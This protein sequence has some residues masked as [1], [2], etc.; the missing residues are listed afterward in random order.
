MKVALATVFLALGLAPSAGAWTFQLSGE[1]SCVQA[2]G[3]AHFA[4]TWRVANP[5]NLEQSQPMTIRDV[6]NEIGTSEA[7]EVPAPEPMPVGTVVQAGETA[8]FDQTFSYTDAGKYVELQLDADWPAH[9]IQVTREA[10]V[11]LRGP[12]SPPPPPP[13]P[14]GPPPPPPPPP[15]PGGGGAGGTPPPP[16]PPPGPFLPPAVCESLSLSRTTV[17]IN[18][19][20]AVRAR[21]VDQ[22][23]APM[24]GVRVTARGAG[25]R[26]SARTASNGVARLMLRPRRSGTIVVRAARSTGCVARMSAIGRLRPPPS[27]LTG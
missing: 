1:A 4:V 20:T 2:S 16:P 15:P 25:I 23:G 18:R 17:S 22:N 24:V 27:D 10:R 14:P 21:V 9:T 19:R 11:D 8:S 3:S 13:P 26:T 7:D 6:E 5:S 12:C